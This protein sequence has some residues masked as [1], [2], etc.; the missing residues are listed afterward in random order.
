[1]IVSELNIDNTVISYIEENTDQFL[2]VE[3]VNSFMQETSGIVNFFN[4]IS[5]LEEFKIILNEYASKEK[6]SDR[7]EYGDFQTNTELSDKVVRYVIGKEVKPE[8]ILEPT[9]GKG[10]F[11]I[12]C[13]ENFTGV[14]KIT[15]V[16]IYKPYVW[17]TKIKVLKF[18]I[19]HKEREM[20]EIEI[21]HANVFDFPFD[22]L[23]HQTKNFETLVIGNPPW[24]TN[25]ELGSIDSK[26]LPRKTNFK[27]HSGFDAM[28]GKGNF[29]IG[30][31]VAL[32]MLKNF[33]SH[34]GYFAFLMKNAV[35]KNLVY[36]Q[37]K[38]KYK[39]GYT[40]K[41]R[42]D[43]KKEF[44][45][46]VD[47]CLF[48]TKLNQKPQLTC[49]E[50]DF[51][52]LDKLTVL[53]WHK[54]KFVY[55]VTGYDAASNLDGESQFVW[56]QGIKHDCSKI[57]ELERFNGHYLNGLNQTVE[58]EEDLLYGLLKSSD[59]KGNETNTYRKITI[60]TQRKIGQ[61]TLYIKNYFPLTFNYLNGNKAHFDNRKSSIYNG[62]PD[63]SIFGVGDY[64]FALYKVAVSGLYK[65]THF[66]LVPPEN[67]KP[68]M[69]D[70]TCYFIGFDNLVFAKIAH[71]SLNHNYAQGFLKSIIFPDSKRSITKDILMRID[72]NK[73]YALINF[74]IIQ[75]SIDGVTVEDWKKFGKLIRKNTPSEQVSL[76]DN[77]KHKVA[78]VY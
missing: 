61:D 64:S 22:K 46:Y 73:L 68:I 14:K 56:R 76:F 34:N 32:M 11:I 41:L 62:K 8:F 21:I 9:C 5:E 51:G 10:N 18:A 6:E 40:E 71:F 63:F 48:L 55:S 50:L 7:R 74:D 52:T 67:G 12:A 45:V 15:G 28:T 47:A 35:A 43:S 49:Q 26:N 69:L 16:E 42:I 13:L 31:S 20:P 70:D 39:I 59:L 19:E 24:V 44:N 36:E 38:N 58:L 33:D 30:E 29:D 3:K 2:E 77:I 17:E 27:M 65:S 4:D 25:S 60:V 57:M 54:N 23:A 75:G 1:M 78:T 66:T 72:F 37:K 53:G